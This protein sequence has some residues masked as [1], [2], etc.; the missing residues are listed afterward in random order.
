[1]LCGL[2]VSAF[3]RIRVYLC[4]SV[5]KVKNK[6]PTAVLAMGSEIVERDQNP[7]ATR[8]NSSAFSSRFN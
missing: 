8:R 7:T 4:S 2:C 1:M 5:V 3:V 6:N